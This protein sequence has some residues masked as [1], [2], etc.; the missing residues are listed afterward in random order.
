MRLSVAPQTV[1]TALLLAAA[2]IRKIRTFLEK[3]AMARVGV[4]PIAR[5]VVSAIHFITGAHRPLRTSSI[6]V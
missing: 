6:D 5:G 2:N 4:T 1:L 3:A